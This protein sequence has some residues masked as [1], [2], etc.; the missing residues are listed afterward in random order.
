[1]AGLTANDELVRPVYNPEAW[2][3]RDK[4]KSAAAS[5]KLPKTECTHPLDLLRQ[6]VD[7]D[8]SMK[9]EGRLVNLFECGVCQMLVWFTDPWGVAVS[10]A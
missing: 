3:M 6:Y 1:M 5:G 4:L 7:D 10:D 2:V 9:R 8:P